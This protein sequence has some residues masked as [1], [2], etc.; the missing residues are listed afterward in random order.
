MIWTLDIPIPTPSLN[1]IQG[2]H[3]AIVRATKRNMAMALMIAMNRAPEIPKAT[4][5]RKLVIIRRGKGTLDQDNLAGG[6]KGLI[7]AIK[8]EGLILDDDQGSI[9]VEFHQAITKSDPHTVVTIE[10]IP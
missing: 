9:E 4:G 7:D 3:W 10:E 8:A 5:K 2:K 1:D 6:C